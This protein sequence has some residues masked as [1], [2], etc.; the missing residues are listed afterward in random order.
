M[1]SH[2]RKPPSQFPSSS[3]DFPAIQDGREEPTGQASP[4]SIPNHPPPVRAPRILISLA[5]F[6]EAGNLRPLVEAIHQFLPE[7]D[8]LVIDDNS[9][10]GTGRI[11]DELAAASPRVRVLHRPAKLGLGTAILAAM[12]DAIEHD[13]D[14][15]INMDADFSHPP[16]FLPDL[17]AGMDRYDVMIG[18]RYVPGGGVEGEFGLKRRFM[19]T[20][21]NMYARLFLGLR[22]R[23]NSGS[24]R[25]YRV[26]KLKRMNLDRVKSRGYSFMEEIL[27]WC[28]HAGCRFGET[29]IL[30]ENRRSGVSKIH[31]G[32]AV[33]A[34]WIIAELGIRRVLGLIPPPASQ[35]GP[36]D[37]TTNTNGPVAG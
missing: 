15:Y 36:E 11:A 6:N 26:S 28:R 23:D 1:T 2:G 19:S 35:E 32:E 20:G 12:R 25:C 10:D 21:I 22:T 24:Y 34:L 27:F 37:S 29:P 31:A 7:A 16:R 30:F 14:Y 4:A 13:Y 3:V 8:V 18:S 5:T 33:K 9:P 17:I